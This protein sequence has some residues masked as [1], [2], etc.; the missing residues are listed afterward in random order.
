M[1]ATPRADRT[2][3]TRAE[4]HYQALLEVMVDRVVGN[5][6]TDDVQLD[7]AARR[8]LELDGPTFSGVF[9]AHE[10][11]AHSLNKQHKRF[12]IMNLTRSP[13]THWVALSYEGPGELLVYDAFGGLQDTPDLVMKHF[14]KS[15]RTDEDVEQDFD[16]NNCG[17]R[18]L[19][20]LMLRLLFGRDEAECI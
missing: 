11:R 13:G 7:R 3:C 2:L 19:A 18:S 6:V 16:E 14:P 15:T 5:G 9:M 20:W 17:A 1:S 8:L 10:L 12:A 4:F